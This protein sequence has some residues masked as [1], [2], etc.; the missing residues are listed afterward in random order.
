MSE[1]A[2]ATLRPWGQPQ[3]LDIGRRVL[4]RGRLG[5]YPEAPSPGI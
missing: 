2:A 4:T 3:G 1:R 5:A